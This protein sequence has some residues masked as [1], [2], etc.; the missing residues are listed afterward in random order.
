MSTGPRALAAEGLVKTFGRGAARVVA[1]D[2]ASFEVRQ[3]ELFTLLGPSGCGKTTTLRLVAGLERPDAGRVVFEGTDWT[4]LPPYRRSVGMVFQSYALFPHMSVFENVAYGLRVRAMP[5]AEVARRV[6]EV[7]ELVGLA[8]TH[9][10]RPAQ[11]SGGQQQRVALARA[12]V[13]HPKLLLLDEPLSNLDAKLRVY[14]RGEIKRIQRQAGICALYVTHDQEEALSI[15][16]RIAVM[17]AGR[18]AQVGAPAEI[19]ERPSS[20]FVAD[21]VGKANFI[22]CTVLGRDGDTY[23]VHTSAGEQLQGRAAAESLPL[24]D[25]AP[26]LLF[27]RP[28]RMTLAAAGRGDGLRA[29]ITD[30]EYLGS[31]VRYTL[32]GAAGPKMLVDAPPVDGVRRAGDDVVVSFSP[33]H[34]QVYPRPA[35]ADTA[36]AASSA[37]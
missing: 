18:V 19:Y 27:L 5:R 14:M 31:L 6:G 26:A 9:A 28:E 10:R 29:T 7:I 3:G 32:S 22:E 20:V 33:D 34:A 16:D 13:Y 37:T 8:G 30:I 35:G 24:A 17:H 2:G 25:G 12:L 21:F 1:A 15:S 36:R 11:L 4:P 23:R